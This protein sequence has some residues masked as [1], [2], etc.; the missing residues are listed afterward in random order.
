MQAMTVSLVSSGTLNC[1][2]EFSL[3]LLPH[4][5]TRFLILGCLAQRQYEDVCLVSLHLGLSCSLSSL[6]GMLSY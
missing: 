4:V 1:G 3:T 6:G 2:N 5:E